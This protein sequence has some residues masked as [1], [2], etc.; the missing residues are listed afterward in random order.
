MA[1]L[2]AGA[3]PI[4]FD[5]ARKLRR[6]LTK[7]R[8]R[9]V[10]VVLILIFG[11]V[12]ARLVQLGLVVQDNTI[13]GQT[14]DL[15]TATR[16]AILD[17]NGLEL[18]VDVRVPLLEKNDILAERNRGYF[19][20]R[21]LAALNLVSSPGAGKTTLLERTL[22]EFGREV[23][24]G[25][26]VGDLETDNDGRRLHRPHAPVAQI[27]TGT[28]C[29]LD[30]SMVAR[31]VES[32]DLAGVKVL[33]IENVGNLVCPASFDLGEQ[34]RVV[35]LST[36]E[37]KDKPLKYPPIF[38]SAHVVLLTKIDVA[39]ALGFKRDVAVENIRRIAP[40]AKLIQLSTRS[41][42]GVDEWYAFL[43]SLVTR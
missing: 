2:D 5:G 7:A 14:R 9:W 18:A 16:P 11:A 1:A 37:G 35:L 4:A 43:R 27:V 28:S 13:E 25:V 12:A 21:G 41:G 36:T 33:F 6:H 39:D 40:T 34:V 32:L 29:H 42:E 15:I 38:K 30:A 23:K 26:L 17:R 8:I 24:C 31:G 20:G 10:V 22:D 19:L 3:D